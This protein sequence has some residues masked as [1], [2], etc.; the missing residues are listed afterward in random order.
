MQFSARVTAITQDLIIPSVVD[1]IL[2]D[3]FIPYR[4]LGNAKKWNG[5]SLKRPVKISKSSLGGSFSGLDTH[6]TA[7]TT[8]KTLMTYYLKGYE[9]PV[10]IAGMDKVV[11]R[12]EAQVI[13]LVKTEMESRQQDAMDD[14]GTMFY[15]DGTGNASKDFN[16]FDNLID[17]GTVS[18]T[19]GGLTRSS[20]TVHLDSTVTSS[21]GTLDLDKLATLTSAVSA[22]SSPMNQP[23]FFL[24][25]PAVGDLYESLLTPTV[26]ANYDAFGL[27][28]VTRSS[29][30]AI[31]SSELKGAQGFTSYTF[32]G[33]PFVPDGKCTSGHLWAVNEN[34][35]EWY[36][37]KDPDLKDI[38]LSSE[39]IE[40]MYN[41]A[42]SKNVGFQ[43]TDFMV[44]INQYGTVAHIYLLGEMVQWN[45]KRSGVLTAITG[46]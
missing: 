2:G 37:L 42:P 27:P 17:D 30:G 13:N 14:L 7:T 23:T 10:S 1:T 8:D 15:A 4:I 32:R 19:I 24:T 43:W 29:R 16:G 3:S 41:D 26:K 21:G 5:E 34:F 25:T 35:V 9:M 40:G 12:T 45:P 39:T 28:V 46:V 18:S 36:G 33:F 31:R 38:S 22:G 6:S 20:Y 44:P 11:N